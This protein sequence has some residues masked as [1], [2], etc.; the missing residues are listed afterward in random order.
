MAKGRLTKLGLGL[1]GTFAD[2]GVA[3]SGA[4]W[5]GDGVAAAAT[6][7]IGLA[8]EAIGAITTAGARHPAARDSCGSPKTTSRGT[9]AATP[10]TSQR[11]GAPPS[12]TAAGDLVSARVIARGVAVVWSTAS[13]LVALTRPREAVAT[14]AT[15]AACSGSVASG[16]SCCASSATS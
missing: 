11:H 5:L 2:G 16:A 4:D 10:I 8:T 12:L 7:R 13:A 3:T 14:F 15:R 1:T 9:T 6:L